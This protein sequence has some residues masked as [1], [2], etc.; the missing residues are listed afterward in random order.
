MS[1]ILSGARLLPPLV[2][3]TLFSAPVGAQNVVLPAGVPL[4]NAEGSSK[5]V[6]L[7]G[8]ESGQ[9]RFQQVDADLQTPQTFHSLAFRRDG[10]DRYPTAFPRAAE[11]EIVLG[12]GSHN[13]FSTVFD[14]NFRW[15]TRTVVYDRAFISLPDFSA[16]PVAPPATFLPA[17]PF[18]RPFVFTGNDALIWEICVLTTVP[19]RTDYPLDAHATAPDQLILH[20]YGIG[21][22]ANRTQPVL[23]MSLASTGIVYSPERR[24]DMTFYVD[25]APPTQI[26]ILLW[27]FAEQQYAFPG[28]CTN[29]YVDPVLPMA[30]PMTNV[31]GTSTMT[32]RVPFND[33][34]PGQQTCHQAV[35]LDP[36]QPYPI[37]VAGSNGTSV[38]VVAPLPRVK[39]IEA[40]TARTVAADH[41][42]HGFG[43]V[44]Q[45]GG[46][47]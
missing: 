18:D 5:H 32:V 35:A 11:I 41:I 4:A 28:L 43:I 37:K 27:S 13:G 29:L 42:D 7:F 17:I 16:P 45:L 20:N 9:H 34:M 44:V 21:C 3:A 8:C 19:T 39:S 26:P 25:R 46:G 40:S 6:K 31:V 12:Q 15:P 1:T 23:P 10:Y 47:R 33:T 2:I 36:D 38:Q 14:D 22:V 30:M 24:I